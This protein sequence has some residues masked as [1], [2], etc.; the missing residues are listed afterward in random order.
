M[1]KKI[2]DMDGLVKKMIIPKEFQIFGQIYKVE[3]NDF[4][5]R[6]ND[7]VGLAVYRENKILL[8]K[9]SKENGRTK[10]MTEQTFLHELMHIIYHSI[11]EPELR[12]NEKL[13]D[14]ISS[15]LHQSLTSM[16]DEL[17]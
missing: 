17:K 7:D 4:L 3:Y 15:A 16:K 8:Q 5:I 12:D 14:L 11:S 2:N 10:N 6:D 1:W 9:P 13:V